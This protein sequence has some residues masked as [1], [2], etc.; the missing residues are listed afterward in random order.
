MIT[1]ETAKRLA[2]A[3]K[4]LKMLKANNARCLDA[5]ARGALGWGGKG[6]CLGNE[7]YLARVL[8]TLKAFADFGEEMALKVALD[9][10]G[11]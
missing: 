5:E 3:E 7:A 2:N 9:A 10:E 11:M 1:Y 6:G 8:P 4:K